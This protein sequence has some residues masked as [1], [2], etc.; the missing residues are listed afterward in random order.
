MITHMGAAPTPR[1]F[2]DLKRTDARP[3]G[4]AEPSFDHLN[5]R[6]GQGWNNVRDLLEEW[7]SEF[8]TDGRPD[9]QGRFRR[10][11]ES[12]FRSAFYELYCH[13]ILR[14]SG[15]TVSTHPALAGTSRKPDFAASRG[16]TDLIVE[17]TTT[18]VSS[19][20]ASAQK[21]DDRLIDG[22]NDRMAIGNFML[23]LEI[24][25]RG[26]ADV[27]TSALSRYLQRWLDTL[28]ADA[29]IAKY[30]EDP[31]AEPESTNWS[32]GGWSLDFTAWPLQR[33][34][35][36]PGGRIIG[37][38]PIDGGWI[39]DAG[40]LGR[41]F[42][43][44][45]SAYGDLCRPFVVT[46]DAVSDFTADSDIVSALYGSNAV[47]YYVNPGPNDP[48]PQ[49]IRLLDGVWRGLQGWQ[50]ARVSAVMTTATLKPWTVGMQTPTLWHH[51]SPDY[52][53][54]DVAP[55]L[56]QARL[57]RPDGQIHWEEPVVAPWRFLGLDEGW[58]HFG[59]R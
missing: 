2:D 17:V 46:V 42:R 33:E 54:G 34:H 15:W 53:V 41:R 9:L 22:V 50:Q 24:D 20:A 10:G 16:G 21:R 35:R 11:R 6:A 38:G 3:A 43:D 7:F 23:S 44:K 45:G 30:E 39:D 57:Y 18:S 37:S 49:Q 14:R 5:R 32:Q 55:L 36:G 31:D 51:P 48:E 40:P 26:G 12:G 28:D 56:K 19:K 13:E 29:L 27:A 8:P 47:R 1:L 58:P 25:H 59:E 52:P 4:Y